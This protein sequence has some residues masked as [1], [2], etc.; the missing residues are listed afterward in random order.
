MAAC[1]SP[2]L[3][4]IV[5]CRKSSS[6]MFPSPGLTPFSRNSASSGLPFASAARAAFI[7]ISAETPGRCVCCA[8]TG[9]GEMPMASN[10]AVRIAA[11]NRFMYRR[12]HAFIRLEFRV[13][14]KERTVGQDRSCRIAGIA[15]AAS[16]NRRRSNPIAALVGTVTTQVDPDNTSLSM[17]HCIV[18]RKSARSVAGPGARSGVLERQTISRSACRR[19]RHGTRRPRYLPTRSRRHR[20]LP[21][22]RH[23]RKHHS[24][25]PR[26]RQ[27]SLSH[28]HWLRRLSRPQFL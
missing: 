23:R 9:R 22:P 6:S 10:S 15:V 17:I 28:N 12:M 21:P 11:P 7:R 4:A 8:S 3:S 26:S 1:Q 18:E 24:Q 16:G 2:R 5:P 20:R 13:E 14:H 19:R 25:Y 27:S